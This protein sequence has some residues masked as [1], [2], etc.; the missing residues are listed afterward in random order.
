LDK[1]SST[2]A[3]TTYALDTLLSLI[4]SD[5]ASIALALIGLCLLLVERLTLPEASTVGADAYQYA[6][7]LGEETRSNLIAILACGSVLLNGISKLDVTSALAEAVKLDGIVA[8]EPLIFEQDNERPI[9]QR[10]HSLQWGM[11][12][13][14]QATPAKTVVVLQMSTR[15]SKK[16]EVV[17]MMGV[18]PVEV[19]AGTPK[20][21]SSTPILD[22]FQ[23]EGNSK[24][25]Y[26]PTLQ[27]LPGKTEFTYIPSNTQEV[28]IL[29]VPTSAASRST[30]TT[31]AILL[32]SNRAKS[33]TPRDVAWCQTLA[34]RIGY[35][36]AA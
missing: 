11:A 36:I 9:F 15:S 17:A 35:M 28:L 18:V 19:T 1:A 6:E 32:G 29:S 24:E 8:S 7:K 25:A 5:A 16:W 14:L 2:A 30:S 20:G 13:F 26:L 23:I 21:L 34:A 31:T 12:S 3:T 10:H 33:F 22:R 27:A 4:S